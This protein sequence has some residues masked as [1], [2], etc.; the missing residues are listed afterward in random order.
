MPDG[1]HDAVH[2]DAPTLLLSGE[3][4]PVTP[5]EFGEAAAATLSHS[6]H[7]VFPQMGHGQTG[8]PC[9][10]ALVSAFFEA[11]AVDGLDTSCVTNVRRPSFTG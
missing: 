3:A 6:L 2:S 5:A 11:G 9:G 10:A 4:D 1:Y 8:A 7:L